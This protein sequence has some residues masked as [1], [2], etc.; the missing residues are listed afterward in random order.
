MKHYERMHGQTITTNH[1]FNFEWSL[2]DKPLMILLI[3][4]QIS[5]K[6]HQSGHTVEGNNGLGIFYPK[7]LW[8]SLYILS[9]TN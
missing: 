5:L 4:G 7:C 9:K 1:Q 3:N 8:A 2:H 6:T